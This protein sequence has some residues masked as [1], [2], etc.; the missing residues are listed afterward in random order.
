MRKS[1]FGQMP[2]A[3][4]DTMPGAILHQPFESYAVEKKINWRPYS[5]FFMALRPDNLGFKS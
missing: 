3:L 5:F 1:L 2:D 4:E